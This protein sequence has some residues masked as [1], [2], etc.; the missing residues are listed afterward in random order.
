M[1]MRGFKIIVLS[2][3]PLLASAQGDFEIEG[4]DL[5]SY[6]VFD[7]SLSA[8]GAYRLQPVV[9]DTKYDQDDHLRRMKT[10]FS[11]NATALYFPKEKIGVGLT[12]SHFQV[13]GGTVNN[14]N[15]FYMK[16]EVLTLPFMGAVCYFRQSDLGENWYYGPLIG[17][18]YFVY[19]QYVNVKDDTYKGDLKS[20]LFPL[21]KKFKREMEDYTY[22]GGTLGLMFALQVQRKIGDNFA[23]GSRLG[24]IFGA[25]GVEGFWQDRKGSSVAKDKLSRLEF[26]ITVHYLKD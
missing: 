21:E 2:L 5:A 17:L 20:E 24:F 10:A 3:L 23:I 22:K 18:G 26:G 7:I 11:Y 9:D 25:S 16:E 8:S 4:I 6:P 13:S 12:Y 19:N 14:D 15:S 1:K